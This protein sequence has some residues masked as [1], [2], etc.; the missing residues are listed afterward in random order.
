MM[1]IGLRRIIV[2][3]VRSL[4][5]QVCE[6][7]FGSSRIPR[8]PAVAYGT[9]LLSSGVPACGFGKLGRG[10]LSAAALADASAAAPV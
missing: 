1:E 10:D 7:L 2:A 9:T 5:H 4:L 8:R 6:V 3:M